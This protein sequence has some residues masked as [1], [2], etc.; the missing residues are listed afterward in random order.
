MCQRSCS[1]GESVRI[2]LYVLRQPPCLAKQ[3]SQRLQSNSSAPAADKNSFN[4]MPLMGQEL[5][6]VQGQVSNE[7]PNTP[8]DITLERLFRQA[9]GKVRFGIARLRDVVRDPQSAESNTQNRELIHRRVAST[10]VAVAFDSCLRRLTEPYDVLL[11]AN[12]SCGNRSVAHAMYRVFL[13]HGY[14]QR[15]RQRRTLRRLR[16]LRC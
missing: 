5:T 8:I 12:K 2:R 10:V 14:I 11:R 16:A 6:L 4:A 3:S 1:E 15:Q 9:R 13:V 7:V